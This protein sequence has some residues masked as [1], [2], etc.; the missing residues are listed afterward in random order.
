MES[1]EYISIPEGSKRFGVGESTLRRKIKTGFFANHEILQE[2]HPSKNGSYRTLVSVSGLKRVV[3]NRRS[4]SG[5]FNRSDEG[6]QPPKPQNG[7][8]VVGDMAPAIEAVQSA[9]ETAIDSLREANE[10]LRLENNALRERV[11][12]ML[13]HGTPEQLPKP[14][15]GGGVV[16]ES[17]GT[18]KAVKA[19][20]KP[21]TALEIVMFIILA[22]CVAFTVL[23]VVTF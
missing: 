2:E 10:H 6:H 16:D 12:R 20:D 5:Q 13:T 3:D 22:C 11:D 14:Q 21:L 8:G 7:G 4:S 1:D 15:S 19:P 18:Q 23:A 17:G 9:Y